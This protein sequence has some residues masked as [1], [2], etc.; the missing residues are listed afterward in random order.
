MAFAR[1]AFIYYDIVLILEFRNF[2]NE[3][4]KYFSDIFQMDC[5]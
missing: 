2:G 1:C 5:F 3:R 4:R